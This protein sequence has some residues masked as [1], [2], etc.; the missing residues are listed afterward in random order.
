MGTDSS[1]EGK[2]EFV[3]REKRGV[4]AYR[5]FCHVSEFMKLPAPFERVVWVYFRG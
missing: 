5:P 2:G 3:L 1:L 4:V